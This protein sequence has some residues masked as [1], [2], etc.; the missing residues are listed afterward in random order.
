MPS[1]DFAEYS[2]LDVGTFRVYNQY[3]SA[4]S[5][6]EVYLSKTALQYGA[7]PVLRLATAPDTFAVNI[8]HIH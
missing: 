5:S 3:T 7:H 8:L 4:S 6:V 1:G 2:N